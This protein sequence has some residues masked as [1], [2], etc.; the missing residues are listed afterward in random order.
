LRDTKPEPTRPDAPTR[1]EKP[2]VA[3]EPA[4]AP[5]GLAA[6]NRA[7]KAE[8][9][10]Y[11]LAVLVTREGLWDWDIPSGI[12]WNSWRTHEMLGLGDSGPESPFGQK[13]KND[14]WM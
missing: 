10:R 1:G 3:C 11:R 8:L 6:E 2:F 12:I 9:E 5:A 14:D 4:D 7:L 13:I